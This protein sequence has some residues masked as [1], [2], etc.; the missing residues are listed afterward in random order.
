[1]E[2]ECSLRKAVFLNKNR[3]MDD[4]QTQYLYYFFL[5][6]NRNFSEIMLNLMAEAASHYVALLRYKIQLQQWMETC[7]KEENFI[8]GY[9]DLYICQKRKCRGQKQTASS[10]VLYHFYYIILTL[11]QCSVKE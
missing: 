4:V 1:M 11:Q 6:K 10:R 9:E 8:E 3:V 5:F 7:T 2:T